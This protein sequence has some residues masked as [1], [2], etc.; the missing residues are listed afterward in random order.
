MPSNSGSQDFTLRHRITA[1]VSRRLQG[2]VYTSK[3]GL[4]KGL[5]RKGGLGFL[6]GVAHPDTAEI[7][8]LQTL[9]FN[10]KVVYD[11]GGFQGIMTLFFAKTARQVI[12][13]EANPV[14]VVRI[15]EN[16]ALNQFKNVFVLNV[17]VGNRDG[18]LSLLVDPLM[19]GA[20]SGD[21]EIAGQIRA[22]VKNAAE[23]TVILTSVDAVVQRF[24]IPAPDFVKIDIEGMELDALQGMAGLIDSKKPDLYLE[25]HGATEQDKRANATDVIEFI[26]GKRYKVFDVEQN[27]DITGDVPTGH[28]SH[29]YCTPLT[30]R[31][32]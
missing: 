20:A 30:N 16:A 14:N 27:R 25:L 12:T 32:R 5:R 10:G 22:D 19:T 28:E 17:A 4:T 9:N 8:F 24:Q 2:I 23:F 26:R 21:P 31:H 3:G 7:R 15:Y 29:I 13:F 1:A 18:T 6:P 11:I